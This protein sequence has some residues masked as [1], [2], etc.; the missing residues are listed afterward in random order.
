[1]FKKFPAHMAAV[2]VRLFREM[3]DKTDPEV[4]KAARI[5]LSGMLG[6]S[7]VFSGVMGMPFY[8]IVRDICNKLLGDDD[9]PYDFDYEMYIY[10]YENLGGD[11][12]N[13][14]TRGWIGDFGADIGTRV[15][16]ESSPLL[17]G[18]KQLPFIGGLLGL[19]DPNNNPSA[20]ATMKDFIVEAIGPLAG[21]PLQVARGIDKLQ[22]G[23]VNRFLEGIAPLAGVRNLLK[24]NRMSEEGALTSRGD[25]I[26]EDL[27]VAEIAAQALGLTPQRLSSQYRLNAQKKDI[28][29]KVEERKQSLINQYFNATVRGDTDRTD[30]LIKE[31]YAFNQAN[32][33]KGVAITGETLRNS[34]KTR[35]KQRAQTQGG[36]YIPKQFK[37]MFSDAPVFAEPEEE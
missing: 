12:A 10:L 6:M 31:M 20:E 5:Q 2:Y 13:R 11:W 19:R 36:V 26:I 25:P 37:P 27:S 17:G 34:A 9:D 29:Q 23:D 4:R 22:Q 32:P 28:Q 18:S 21:M 14:I 16:Y 30:E 35:A 7:A 1:M 15:S 3:F 33:Y 24:A 8:Y